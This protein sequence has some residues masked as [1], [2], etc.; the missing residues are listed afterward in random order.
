[1]AS[2]ALPG[3][4]AGAGRRRWLV[5][6]VISLAQLMVTLDSTIVAIALPSAQHS[7]AISDTDRQWVI[8]AYTLAFGGLLLL[9]GRL[10]DLLGRRRSLLVGLIGFAIVSA[11]GGAAPNGAV[12]IAARAAQGVFAAVLTPSTL[13][14]V[15]VTFTDERQRGKAF[16]VFGAI[17]VTGGA[18]GLIGGGLITQSLDWRWCLYVNVPIALIALFGALA[19]L[20][21]TPGDKPSTVDLPGCALGCGAMLSMVYGFNLAATR[22]WGSGLVIGLLAGAVVLA[23]AFLVVETRS[24]TPLLPLRLIGERNRAGSLISLALASFAMFGMFLFLTYQ[25]QAVMHYSPLKAG[26]AFLPLLVSNVLVSGLVTGP[27]LSR[28]P[29]RLLLGPGLLIAAAGLLLLTNLSPDSQFLDGILPAELILGAGLGTVMAPSASTATAGV[30]PEVQGVVSA[31]VSTSQQIGGAT[32]TALL[33]TIA[34][35]ATATYLATR[36]M[37]KPTV[38][39]GTVH[40]YST[41]GVWAAGVLVLAAV[42]A[43]VLINAKPQPRGNPH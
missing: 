43:V 19:L 40:G 3:Q 41:A 21:P 13:A 17:L 14:L 31:S 2:E 7:L 20:P 35:N 34:T 5:L 15:N 8:T 4:T 29:P 33:N 1:M 22:G 9:G 6:V 30:G 23:T 28:V 38:I 27:L 42:V 26:L 37:D 32:G 24:A 12:L 11:I 36:P 25:L 16:G 18:L 10:S 39:A